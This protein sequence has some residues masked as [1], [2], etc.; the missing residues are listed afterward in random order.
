MQV[1]SHTVGHPRKRAGLA[2]PAKRKGTRRNAR[3][4][5][6][7]TDDLKQTADE[8]L[9]ELL[10]QDNSEAFGE[11]VE[12]YQQDVFLFCRYYLRNKDLAQ[13]HAQETFV[14][15]HEARHNFDV[16]RK[17]KPWLLCIARNMCLN[18]LRR[19]ERTC[20]IS[21]EAYAG[22]QCGGMQRGLEEPRNDP[23]AE[24]MEREQRELLAGA[25][26]RLP[27]AVRRIV[28]LRYFQCFSYR[29][30]ARVVGGTEGAVR[31]KLHRT[32]SVLRD[33]V[34]VKKEDILAG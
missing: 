25:M 31:I 14:R 29:Q 23:Q 13:E 33:K 18:T 11:L 28:E 4:E 9:M 3:R 12:R 24:A 20:T 6:L 17:L 2:V 30:I 21:L 34:G 8:L 19:K 16:R 15:L 10:R 27:D 7:A 32:L 1:Q 5:S 26:G 22:E